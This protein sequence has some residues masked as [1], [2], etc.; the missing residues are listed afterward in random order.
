MAVLLSTGVLCLLAASSTRVL[1]ILGIPYCAVPEH[2]MA[3]FLASTVTHP[4][5][6][7]HNQGNNAGNTIS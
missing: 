7:S 1:Y 2:S 3:V 6:K 4:S 5:G